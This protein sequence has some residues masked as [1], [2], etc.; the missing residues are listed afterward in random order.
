MD[1]LLIR[2]QSKLHQKLGFTD[3]DLAENFILAD[4]IATTDVFYLLIVL[5]VF[6]MFL[7]SDRPGTTYSSPPPLHTFGFFKTSAYA[8]LNF[9]IPY[10]FSVLLD[11]SENFQA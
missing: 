10:T 4:N 5:K 2:K 1:Y 3:T 6:L 11:T 7:P 8:N 9:G